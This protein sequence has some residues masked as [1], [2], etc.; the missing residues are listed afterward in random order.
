[1]TGATCNAHLATTIGPR[2]EP[3]LCRRWV[4][5]FAPRCSDCGEV[6]PHVRLETYI[7]NVQK[8][9]GNGSDVEKVMMRGHRRLKKGACS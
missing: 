8:R 9:A 4:P 2:R 7:R 6:A 1:M 3:V 5:S